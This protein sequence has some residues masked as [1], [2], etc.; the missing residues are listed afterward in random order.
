MTALLDR[1][2][3]GR[4]PTPGDDLLVLAPHPDD[5][6]IGAA[7]L[8]GWFASLGRPIEILAVTDGERSHAR[9]ERITPD[10]LRRR[11]ALERTAAI[12]VLGLTPEVSRLGLPDGQVAAFQDAL[13]VA[14]ADRAGPTTTV[15]APWRHDGHPDHDAVG[16]AAWTA[17]ECT[18]ATLW[19][20]PI[21]AKVARHRPARSPVSAQP[22]RAG[23]R[24]PGAEGRC[25]ALL[26][27]AA[28][29]SGPRP[30]RRAG[31]APPRAGGHA[32]RRG[33]RPVA[34]IRPTVHE[35]PVLRG[36]LGHRRRSL[37]ARQ[38]LVRAS[39]VRADGGCPPRA[40][41][42]PAASN[43]AAAPACS[44]RCSPSVPTSTSPWNVTRVARR[45]PRARCANLHNVRTQVGTIPD[46]WPSG[47]LRP[48]RPV[49]DPLLP[50]SAVDRS[51]PGALP[52]ARSPRTV[53][54]WP[55]TTA[56]RWTPTR[57]PATRCHDMLRSTPG[58]ATGTHILD[59]EFVL[60][61]LAP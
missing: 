61:V 9:S 44:R 18:G 17:A 1:A 34:L 14:I 13:T 53:T 39:Q 54:S 19:E 5:E 3:V 22:P 49:R 45:R 55:C 37:G 26:H 60:D 43:R 30:A 42:T 38:P 27:D 46:D 47:S 29:A 56:P 2:W 33:A 16:R 50:R 52:D 11:R 59:P 36:D 6:V 24:H 12:E 8:M 4:R 58:W 40:R 51:H 7:G 41:G 21:W 48:H 28:R 25:G 35:R 31:G 15:I 10:D 20:I 23:R 32:R 57:G